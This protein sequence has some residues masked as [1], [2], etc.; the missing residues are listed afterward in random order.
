MYNIHKL[1]DIN[2]MIESLNIPDYITKIT[3]TKDF[4]RYA[5][6]TKIVETANKEMT[7]TE[8]K[9]W[10]VIDFVESVLANPEFT[11]ENRTIPRSEF[12]PRELR[13][14]DMLMPTTRGEL[15]T[16]KA[17]LEE[18]KKKE[19]ETLDKIKDSTHPDDI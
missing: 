4:K 2:V 7:N 18:N 6:T 11:D 8:D 16:K 10:K 12:T 3:F 1:A 19:E 14:L 13:G 5:K 15:I 9:T 17:E